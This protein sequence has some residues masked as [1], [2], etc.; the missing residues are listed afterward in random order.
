MRLF[1][2]TDMHTAKISIVKAMLAEIDGCNRDYSLQVDLEKSV[3]YLWQKHRL[4]VPT[5]H[6]DKKVI[7]N[8]GQ[9]AN[10]VYVTLSIPYEGSGK[11]LAIQ[12]TACLGGSPDA[13]I[14]GTDFRITY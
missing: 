7:V 2:G 12:P 9:S 5:I 6:F 11:V 1:S 10:G 13:A 4:E 3:E 14:T 8:E